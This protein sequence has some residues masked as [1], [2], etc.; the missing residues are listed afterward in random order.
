MTLIVPSHSDLETTLGL[1]GHELDESIPLE[2]STSIKPMAVPNPLDGDTTYRPPTFGRSSAAKWARLRHPIVKPARC[3]AVLGMRHRSAKSRLE[4]TRARQGSPRQKPEA[5][6]QK[7]DHCCCG[8][9]A[10][11][12]V[13]ISLTIGE[14][15]REFIIAGRLIFR[16]ATVCRPS[17]MSTIGSVRW[18][19]LQRGRKRD[20]CFLHSMVR[21]YPP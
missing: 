11:F 21:G 10:L 20:E 8:L 3:R 4:R 2:R 18:T 13:M 17:R 19:M 16:K 6:T 12:S 15:S 1:P 14:A 9:S 5:L 7:R